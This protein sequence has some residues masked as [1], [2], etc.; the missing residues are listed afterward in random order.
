MMKT[1]LPAPPYVSGAAPLVGHAWEFLKGPETLLERGLIE[2]G[3]MFSLKLPALSAVVMAGPEHSAFVFTETD[4]RLSIRE[5]YPF[6]NHMFGSESYFLADP[7]EYHRQRVIILPRF[8]ASQ[9]AGHLGV[10]DREI[11]AFTASLPD[12]TTIDL[13]EALGPLVMRIA[14]DCFLGSGFS[15]GM[16]GFFELFRVFSQGLDPLLPGWF[17]APHLI[18]SHRARDQLRATV[19]G[20]LEERRCR[21][22]E[23]P[24][25]LQQLA[26]ARYAD[27]SEVTD[28][29]REGLALMLIWVGH[30][31]TAGH[32]AWALIDLLQH[33]EEMLRVQEEQ[34]RVLPDREGEV[35]LSLLRRLEHLQRALLE[36]ERLHP[37]TNGVVRKATVD[38]EYCGRLIRRGT[39][40]ILH[41]RLTHRLSEV[42]P[43]PH[44]Y[45]PDRFLE[46]PGS[47][48]HL[49]G[50]GGGLHRC[51]GRHFAYT[52]LKVAIVRLLQEFTIELVDPTP[53][54]APGQRT[55]WP[56][57]PCR[58][59]LYR[60][61]GGQ[62]TVR[63]TADYTGDR[64]HDPS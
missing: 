60:R 16:N 26:E 63:G 38:I 57:S 21:P 64:A 20:L 33:P 3:T 34:Q 42:F 35:S 62:R 52:E 19:R 40:V 13:I 4:K 17:P 28:R 6:F 18:R 23:A 56:Q 7:E 47:A 27:G 53:Q 30:E 54:P 44:S 1:E 55:K 5:A 51:L 2:H 49:I 10:M 9:T 25:F 50:F 39:A 11:Q 14:A 48:Q 61:P 41:P 43:A 8:R 32:L 24:D 45:R 29:V 15:A 58:V 22:L 31:T 46:D 36:S 59:R 37:L 12:E